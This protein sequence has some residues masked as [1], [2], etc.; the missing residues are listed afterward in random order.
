MGEHY[1]ELKG[2][3]CN[4]H[5]IKDEI[6]VSVH[7]TRVSLCYNEGCGVCAAASFVRERLVRELCSDFGT[8]RKG[9]D[10]RCECACRTDGKAEAWCAA[11]GG[12]SAQEER[13]VTGAQ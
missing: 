6:G 13:S 1:K 10:E 4:K 7:S 11:R 5:T 12:F 3:Y 8:E 2:E 9:T